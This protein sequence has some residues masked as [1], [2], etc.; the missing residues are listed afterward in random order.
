M[1]DFGNVHNVLLICHIL[2]SFWLNSRRSASNSS[3]F[4][5]AKLKPSSI[6]CSK[7]SSSNDTG[8]CNKDDEGWITICFA[9]PCNVSI[10]FS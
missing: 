6:D 7:V 2:P 9:C 3:N 8:T 5:V 10:N 1:T 4:S